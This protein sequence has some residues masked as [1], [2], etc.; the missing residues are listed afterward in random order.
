MS[1]L[2]AL[3]LLLL[4]LIAVPVAAQDK[5]S[6]GLPTVPTLIY[7]PQYLALS[8]GLFA[9]EGIEVE[10]VI[11]DGTATVV[12]Q[13]AQRRITTAWINPDMLIISAQP[14]RDKL[15]LRC[16]YNGLRVT[17]WEFVVL[18]DSP[19]R[20]L[21]DLKGAN[22]GMLSMAVGNVPITR[23]LLRELGMEPGRDY[24]MV[25]V[26][27]GAPAFRALITGQIDVLNLFDGQHVTLENNGTRIRRLAQPAKYANQFNNCWVAHDRTIAEQAELLAGF[28]RAFAKASIACR[29]NLDYCV[30]SFWRHFPAQK[31]T[32]VSEQEALAAGVRVVQARIERLFAFADGAD[33]R[34]GGYDRQ[35]WVDF[36]A[37]LHAGGQ[38]ASDQIAPDALYTNDL[39]PAFND[40]DQD[41]FAALAKSWQ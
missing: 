40:F 41:A 15:P 34:L 8:Q 9:E 27:Q 18:E 33:K 38:I 3:A 11:F 29:A 17:A 16:F 4:A 39:V 21:A 5:M 36:I 24:Q 2:A 13:V 26:G 32:E 14:G 7:A 1:R 23:A 19:I 22:V 37:M 35:G 30:K 6:V 20:I 31:P 12:P 10:Y 25:P 28:G